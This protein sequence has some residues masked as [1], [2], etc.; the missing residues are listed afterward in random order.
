MNNSEFETPQEAEAAFYRAFELRDLDA[1]M[2][3]WSDDDTIECIHPMQNRLQ[4]HAAIRAS[5]AEILKR[6]PEITF[7][8]TE[9]N[10]INRGNL[11]IHVI[12]EN[13]QLGDNGLEKSCMITTN[14]YE[15]TASGW[16]MILHHA[17]PTP[18]QTS[19][20]D[21]TSSKVLH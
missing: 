14:I 5:W 2:L 20:T 15:K 11:S 18:K 21:T 10:I 13:L 17:S 19:N 6:A 3:V 1:L 8:N 16:K 4:G 12:Y 9:Q 7:H